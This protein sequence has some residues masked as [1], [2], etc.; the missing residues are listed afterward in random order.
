[1]RLEIREAEDG[2]LELGR[3]RVTIA[4]CP[5]AEPELVTDFDRPRMEREHS[6]ECLLP[7]RTRAKGL[8][9]RLVRLAVSRR[10]IE[11]AAHEHPGLVARG[12]ALF[13]QQR[14]GPVDAVLR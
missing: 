14:F 12:V 13:C 9:Q 10:A 8:R 1:M 5:E 3:A 7:L 4:P 11:R 2:F 6:S